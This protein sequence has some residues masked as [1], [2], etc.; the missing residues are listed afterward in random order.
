[1]VVVGNRCDGV[2][3]AAYETETSAARARCSI[4][5]SAVFQYV[6]RDTATKKVDQ[7]PEILQSIRMINTR[8][9]EPSHSRQLPMGN[10]SMGLYELVAY[11]I[12]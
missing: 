11:Y 5:T 12:K 3:L 6:C 9:Q 4:S 1:M 10:T 7:Y 8:E 2:D